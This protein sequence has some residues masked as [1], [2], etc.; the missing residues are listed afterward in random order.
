MKPV[1]QQQGRV[2]IKEIADR[3]GISK[4]TVSRA[5][6]NRARVAPETREKVVKMAEE[7]GYRPDPTLRALSNL[8]WTRHPESRTVYRIALLNMA[9]LDET[10]QRAETPAMERVDPAHKGVI[11]RAADLG[12]DLKS[13]T[14]KDT[15]G[16]MRF[17]NIL[18]HR[19][20]DG[21][22]FGVRCPVENW[23][24]PYERFPC[25]TIS[26]DHP[27][28]A[29]HQVTSDWFNAV[30]VATSEVLARG[31]KRPGFLHYCR[32]N[33]SIDQRVWAAMLASREQFVGQ[34]GSSPAIF[35]YISEGKLGK[36]F[37]A[38]NAVLFKKWL[39]KEKPDV[40][41]DG[42]FLGYWW[43]KDAGLEMPDDIG[44]V[45]LL[46]SNSADDQLISA[47]D[48]NLREQGRWAVD[49]LY[50]M[51]QTGSRGLPERPSRITVGCRM[52]EGR[53]LRPRLPEAL[54]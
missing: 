14:I 54:A 13:F 2:T 43:L 16:L 40:V 50:N 27:S 47:V 45:R 44:A 25:L 51:I 23:S 42:G 28:H 36:A 4:A 10:Q 3:L 21:I 49:L 8:R 9:I 1:P 31:Y 48:H 7:L 46:V 39:K 52:S 41:I 33:P 6:L 29:M 24:F 17:G 38:E 35:N 32:G 19:G 37:Y 34:F 18:F 11:E 20:Y 12:M 22:I 53:T 26:Y 15:K 5:L 30:S